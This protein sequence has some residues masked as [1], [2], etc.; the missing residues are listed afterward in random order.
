MTE[1]KQEN[2][3]Q[4]LGEHRQESPK[5]RTL[6]WAQKMFSAKRCAVM[7]LFAAMSLVV[8]FFEFPIFPAAPF[9]MLD[10]GNCFIM[11]VGFLLGPIEGLIVCVIKETLRILLKNGTGGVGELANMLVTSA[12][13]LLP[14]TV[15]Y[16][17]KGLKVVVPTLI[18]A[19]FIAA[20]VALI[21][22]RIVLF[23]AYLGTEGAAM[24]EQLWWIVLL[25]NLINGAANTVL[26][27]ALYK[28]L[29]FLFKKWKI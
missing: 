5:K 15:Y 26:T 4:A 23:P 28:K 21:V 20:G 1:E 13:I 8:S 3:Q 16:F 11:L 6:S 7:A 12:Y 18:A 9:L 25:F 17:K 24:F 2:L 29:S 27:V 22:N 10:F 19:C 14:A